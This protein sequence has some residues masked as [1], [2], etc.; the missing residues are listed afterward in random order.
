MHESSS[1]SVVRRPAPTLATSSITSLPPLPAESMLESEMTYWR[2]G[3]HFH[4][5]FDCFRSTCLNVA[6]SPSWHAS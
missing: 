2:T 5:T 6:W 4:R 1:I 3:P